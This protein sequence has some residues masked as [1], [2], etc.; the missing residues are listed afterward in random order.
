MTGFHLLETSAMKSAPIMIA[1]V[2]GL[3]WMGCAVRRPDAGNNRD[4]IA[5]A[6]VQDQDGARSEVHTVA[7]VPPPLPAVDL[8]GSQIEEHTES[9][10][11]PDPAQ[12]EQLTLLDF[13]DMAFQNN[14]TLAAAAARMDRS[15]G[16]QLQAGLFPNPVIGY[17][18][19]EVGNLGTAGAQGAF[20]GQRLITGGKLRLD[21]AIA[22]REYDEAHFRFH[23]Q[24]K[25]VLSDVRIRYY[26]ALVA[27]RRVELTKELARISDD[28]VKATETLQRGR[29]ATENDLLQAKIRADETH[30]LAD[31]ALNEDVEAWRRLLAVAG[32][33]SMPPSMLV[34]ELTAPLAQLDWD[35]CCE[36]VLAGNPILI[37]ARARMQRAS[38]AVSRARKEPIPD[39][40]L[41]VSVRHHNVTGDDVANVQVGIPLPIFDRNQG[42]IHSAEAEWSAARS[43]TR[44]IELELQ[45]R[46]ATAYRKYANSRQQ[47]DRYRQRMV[48]RARRSLELVTHGY[49]KGQV[50]YLTLLNSQQTFIEVNLA[51]L[52]ALREFRASFS[53]IEGQLLSG[54]LS[55]QGE[56]QN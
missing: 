56:F 5:T 43:D 39:V 7:Y 24:E 42:N 18:S 12:E 25:R 46:L 45:D 4:S 35:D 17:H 55:R 33:P 54:S 6:T 44:R 14:P 36:M 30:I 8:D 2:F 48:P 31:N 38:V 52:E 3:T 23:A 37:A 16:R 53:S 10:P 15:R 41:S 34:G 28:L 19:T 22:G 20:V 9:L 21:R 51:Y 40:D 50:K 32:V 27:Q 13:E 29:L 49:A 11:V 47:V 1:V 26:D